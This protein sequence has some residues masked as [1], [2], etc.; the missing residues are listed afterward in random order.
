MIAEME[1]ENH[2]WTPAEEAVQVAQIMSRDLY[3]LAHLWTMSFVY[4]PWDS[5]VCNNHLL[6]MSFEWNNLSD[7]GQQ[8]GGLLVNS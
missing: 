8:F 6:T 2:E 5:Y 4:C 1:S 7:W 3:L